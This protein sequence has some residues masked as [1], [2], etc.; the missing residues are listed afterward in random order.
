MHFVRRASEDPKSQRIR[1]MLL[2]RAERLAELLKLPVIPK[3]TVAQEVLMV[4]KAGLAYCDQLLSDIFLEWL[5]NDSPKEVS[6][7]KNCKSFENE[8]FADC[9]SCKKESAPTN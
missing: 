7:C 2:R 8:S 9:S 6:A 4:F 5:V 1:Q 3:E